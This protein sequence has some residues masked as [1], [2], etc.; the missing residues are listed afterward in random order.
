MPPSPLKEMPLLDRVSQRIDRFKED[1][2]LLDV[3]NSQATAAA[4]TME[5][6]CKLCGKDVAQL[7]G[8]IN[9]M[10]I[11]LRE[12]VENEIFKVQDH[13]EAKIRLMSHEHSESVASMRAAHLKAIDKVQRA[14]HGKIETC[15]K[16]FQEQIN[17]STHLISALS[18]SSSHVPSCNS[19]C[20]SR[21]SCMVEFCKAQ[22]KIETRLTGVQLVNA[23]L[24]QEL[25]YCSSSMRA[26]E[27]SL[28]S[29]L[30]GRAN[31]STSKEQH[32]GNF[33]FTT[34]IGAFG[35]TSGG[36]GQCGDDCPLSCSCGTNIRE[37]R[38]DLEASIGTQEDKFVQVHT[39]NRELRD[40]L[41]GL[42][43]A[44][45]IKHVPINSA[46]PSSIAALTLDVSK[47]QREVA[48][49]R[50]AIEGWEHDGVD[51]AKEFSDDESFQVCSSR[52]SGGH[53]NRR[54]RWV[55]SMSS[56]FYGRGRD[57]TSKR[58]TS[59]PCAA[60]KKYPWRW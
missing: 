57:N 41:V 4:S 30:Q 39:S 29:L 58:S 44:Q 3:S 19:F 9:K 60:K 16:R 25:F 24:G 59:A 34:R 17:H 54:T 49:V 47:L 13:Y 53:A 26:N 37:V 8:D 18:D 5:E 23:T 51:E 14:C 46:P 15:E 52:R 11:A 6:A 7:R 45:A 10:D 31:V 55:E 28:R 40:E 1:L 36:N 38:N 27:T 35:D 50:L 43:C 20:D 32:A 56:A 12:F 21:C 42:S 22:S 2:G 48:A 33:E